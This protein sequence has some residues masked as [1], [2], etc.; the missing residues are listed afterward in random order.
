MAHRGKEQGDPLFVAADVGGLPRGLDHQHLVAGRIGRGQ[1]RVALSQLIAEREPE[2][3]DRI[4]QLDRHRDVAGEHQGVRKI[5]EPDQRIAGAPAEALFETEEQLLT[6]ARRLMGRLPLREIDGEK[7]A[8][9][10]RRSVGVVLAAG[11]YPGSY[12]KGE[13]IAGLPLQEQEGRKLFH[14]GTKERDGNVVTAGGRVLC[15]TALGEIVAEAQAAAYRLAGQISWNG[16]FYRRDIG[17]R[18]I[19]REE[20]GGAEA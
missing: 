16:V 14:A 2:L 4:H 19:A 6:E 15:A 5:E 3:L 10:P 9:D 18:A 1:R 7:A 8:W 12:A 13:V 11:G 20:Q 17:Y